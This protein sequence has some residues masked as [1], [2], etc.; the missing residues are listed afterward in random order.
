[1]TLVIRFLEEH[2]WIRGIKCRSFKE[3]L[4]LLSETQGALTTSGL[5]GTRV[6]GRDCWTPFFL[7]LKD[8]CFKYQNLLA[9]PA[10]E[11]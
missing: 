1:M 2:T 5:T 9:V 4:Y 11:G 3:L 7:Q 8:S 10:E 6:V